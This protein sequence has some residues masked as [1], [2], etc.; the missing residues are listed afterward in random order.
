MRLDGGREVVALLGSGGTA[1]PTGSVDYGS[2]YLHLI[3]LRVVHHHGST[4]SWTKSHV[5]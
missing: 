4:K 1:T 3:P 2:S 5:K